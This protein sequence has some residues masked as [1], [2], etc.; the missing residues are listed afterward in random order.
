MDT[1]PPECGSTLITAFPFRA[2]VVSVRGGGGVTSSSSSHEIN[3]DVTRKK[4]IGE[5]NFIKVSDTRKT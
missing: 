1:H 5:S 3:A 4:E 2:V